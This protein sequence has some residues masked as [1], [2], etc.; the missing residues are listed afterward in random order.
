VLL[1][2]FCILRILGYS[3]NT[4][5]MFGLVLSIGL[6]VDDAIVVVE[7][8][9]RLMREDKLSPLEATV[10]SMKEI[11]GAL[12]GVATVLSAVFLP[13]AFF[14]GA[15]GII[16][17]Q[18]SI[19]IVASMLLSVVVALTVTP[20]MCASLLRA[21]HDDTAPRRGPFGLFN[22]SFDWT[23]SKYR[24]AV[25]WLLKGP[26]KWLVPYA[27]ICA[28]MGLLLTRLPTGF[29][30]QEDQG[31]GMVI[32]TLPAGATL[33]RTGAV[34]RAVEQHYLGVEKKNVESIFTV[35][36]FSFIGAGQNAGMAFV[37]LKDWDERPGKQNTAAA[38]SQRATSC[39]G[40][41]R[42]TRS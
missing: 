4:L 34:A 21:G 22:R 30:P 15:T 1:G 37:E 35:S 39:S 42:R 2:T 14:S 25:A 6:L 24:T 27:A 16:Y 8:V 17:R 20:A 31:T 9:E 19:T 32:W 40:S 23:T 11:T 5:T 26:W 41:P 13:M 18:F 29:L 3:I 28:A 7:N 36:G 10:R 33:P 12:I 38:I